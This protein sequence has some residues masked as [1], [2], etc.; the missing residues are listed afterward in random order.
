MYHTDSILGSERKKTMAEPQAIPTAPAAPKKA[1]IGWFSFTCC[2][3]NTGLFAEILNANYDTWKTLVD[4][5][6]CRQLKTKND[7]HNLDVAFIEG[8]ISGKEEIEFLK[9]IRL[10]AKFVVAVGSC[11]C[12]GMPSASRNDLKPD[13]ID[14][15]QR[16][17]MCKFDYTKDVHPIG[18]YIIVDDKVKGC[19]MNANLFIAAVMKYLKLMGLV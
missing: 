16:F 10:N 18:D 5:K 14:Y 4:I 13:Q 6:Y 11:A 12:N 7:Y 1:A 2:E 3:D 17:H 19:P 8:A 9:D 15:R